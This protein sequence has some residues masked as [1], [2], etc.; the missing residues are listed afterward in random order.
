MVEIAQSDAFLF[1][2]N[3]YNIHFFSL[4]NI[5]VAESCFGFV[6]YSELV[7]KIGTTIGIIE[8]LYKVNGGQSCTEFAILDLDWFGEG[9]EET[10]WFG[11]IFL[12]I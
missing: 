8:F 10:E 9:C 2:W 11:T 1:W 5:C 12:Q 4:F 3:L 7:S 6:C